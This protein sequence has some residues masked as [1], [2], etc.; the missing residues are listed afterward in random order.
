MLQSAGLREPRNEISPFAP[1]LEQVRI[2]PTKIG[3]LIGPKGANIKKLQEE[4]KVTVEVVDDSGLVHVSGT[5]VENVKLAVDRIR[6]MTAEPEIGRIYAGT[7]KS[8]KEFGAFVEIFPG[9]EG[10]C[11][12]SELGD[13]YVK[14]VTDV[15]KVGDPIKVK[16]INIDETGRVKLSAK[17]LNGPPAPPSPPR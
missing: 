7:V 17:G 10:L 14:R 13:G 12:V 5:R 8:V 4:F 16:V 1:R 9:V 2:N 11:H 6:G 15:V 3:A